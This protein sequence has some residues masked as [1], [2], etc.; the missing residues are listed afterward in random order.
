MELRATHRFDAPAHAVA[1]A[2]TDPDFY[3]ALELP[4]VETPEIL[5]HEATD[6]SVMLRV[7]LRFTGALD[8]VARRVI[9]AERIS[10]VQE[11]RLDLPTRR[12]EL[13]VV[14]DVQQDRI[15]LKAQVELIEDS[16]TATTRR[17][18]GDLKVRIPLVGGRAERS[19]VPGIERRLDAEAEALRDWLERQGLGPAT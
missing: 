4:D 2:S 19:L 13:T 1:T 10:W 14:P 3:A 12:G 15:D 18:A 6:V 7:R 11:L 17:I 16:A 5:A 8:P 9:G